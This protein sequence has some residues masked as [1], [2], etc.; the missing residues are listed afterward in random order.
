MERPALVR[1]PVV[2]FLF[3]L[4]LTV[5]LPGCGHPEP[6]EADVKGCL[7]NH[8][9]GTGMTSFEYGPERTIAFEFKPKV[10]G[11]FANVDITLTQRLDSGNYVVH[12]TALLKWK[13]GWALEE[14]KTIEIKKEAGR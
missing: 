12:A 10:D 9:L 13:A 1:I 5:L 8:Y 6:T 14:L 7:D 11:D 2:V 4:V 3:F